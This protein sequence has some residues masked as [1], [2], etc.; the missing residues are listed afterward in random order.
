[1]KDTNVVELVPDAVV[2]VPGLAV[3]G[4]VGELVEALDVSEVVDEHERVVAL[5]LEG[6]PGREVVESVLVGAKVQVL[7]HGVKVCADLAT[8]GRE[9]SERMVETD[10]KVEDQQRSTGR[11]GGDLAGGGV[12]ELC[13]GTARDDAVHVSVGRL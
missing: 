8:A 12:R 5:G 3:E 1:M 2:P 11:G 13:G 10:S 9:E 6:L 4:I 7:V